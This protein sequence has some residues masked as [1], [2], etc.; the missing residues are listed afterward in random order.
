MTDVDAF[1]DAEYI[2]DVSGIV[3]DD[4]E[5]G[6]SARGSN[7]RVRKLQSSAKIAF[8]DR[9][10]RDL[11]ILIYCELSALYYMD[12]SVVLFAIRAIVELIF[13]TPKAPPFDPT[14]NQPFV[15]AIIASNLFCMT[16]HA[17]FIRPEAGEST[18]GYLHGGLFID[19][20]GQK[21]VPVLRLLLF[22]LLIFLIDF[23]MLALIIE[24]VKTVGMTPT[25]ST[26]TNTEPVSEQQ[27]HD[28]EERG[29]VRETETMSPIDTSDALPVAEIDEDVNNERTT[30][31]ADPGES[32]SAQT[33]RGGHPLDSYSSGQATILE[34]GFFS[35]VR[36]QWKYSTTP[37]RPTTGYVPTP[38][39]ATFLRQRFGL[40]VGTDGRI[41]RVDR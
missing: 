3:L 31:L 1:R 4:A 5:P 15:G 40:Q 20:I 6:S 9:L 35:T 36:D 2:A 39:T 38:E 28:A 41:V 26:T 14:R 29:V 12:C 32:S 37:R 8:I 33:P 30:L 13:F 17:F 27:D 22:D 34:M 24:R 18:R 11:D 23:V 21:P 19:F 10:L 7:S 16:F 25:P